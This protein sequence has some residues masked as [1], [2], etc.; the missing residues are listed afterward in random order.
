MHGGQLLLARARTGL[1]AAFRPAAGTLRAVRGGSCGALG[2]GLLLPRLHPGRLHRRG[3]GRRLAPDPDLVVDLAPGRRPRPGPRARPVPRRASRAASPGRRV[4]DHRR[5]A[6]AASGVRAPAGFSSE[7]LAAIAPSPSFAAACSA[8]FFEAAGAL[9]DAPRRAAPAPRRT[10]SS[11]R[12][13]APRRPGSAARRAGGSAP[14]L[15]AGSCSRDRASR[16]PPAR[17]RRRGSN[18]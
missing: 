4:L 14:A 3:R 6:V 17:R 12:G 5:L 16:R 10:P 11:G 13:R 8:S 1:R 15:A 18:R 7:N 2:A 9:P